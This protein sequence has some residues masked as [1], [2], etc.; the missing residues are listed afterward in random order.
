[1]DDEAKSKEGNVNTFR[2]PTI[3]AALGATLASTAA[4]ALHDDRYYT[5][6]SY[7]EPYRSREYV[8]V[9]PGEVLRVGRDGTIVY[10]DGRY[11]EPRR[12]YVERD[13]YAYAPREYR[14]YPDYVA[15][16]NKQTGPYIDHG[17]F[18]RR[19]PNDFGQ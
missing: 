15:D 19:G 4:L 8:R 7:D 16:L 13:Y 1:M 14:V 17:L 10:R 6:R 5:Y 2:I 3:V 9:A 18:N 12:V 11:V